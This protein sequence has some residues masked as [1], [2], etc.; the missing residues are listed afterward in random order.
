[1]KILYLSCH[2][3]L[4]FDEVKLLHELGH[5]VFSPGAYVEPANPGDASLRPGIPELVYDPDVLAAFHALGQPGIDN[6]ELLTKEFVDRF[7]LIIIMHMPKWII[8]NWE[9]MKH[10]PVIWRTIG[11]SITSVETRLAEYRDSGMKI[12]RY[13]PMES[14][15]PGYLGADALIRFYK[16]PEE[17]K[18]WSGNIRSIISFSQS[19]KKR[20][21]ACNFSYFEEITRG[22][23]RILYGP[24]NEDIFE[25]PTG[26]KLPFDQLQMQLR[27]NRV[28]FYTGTHPASYTLNFMEAWMT[29]IPIV[30][31][32]QQK[33]NANYFPSHSLYEIP[34]LI[35]NGING[36]ISEDPK[37]LRYICEELLS[38]D[39][40]ARDIG[41]AGRKSAIDIFGKDIIKQQWKEFLDGMLK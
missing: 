39:F 9:V 28:Y 13:S 30:A 38:N 5:Q 25:M 22:L 24:G 16:D 27:E 23:P 15:I 31:I 37:E 14:N 3:I 8:K 21:Q 10:K 32:G 2:S 11:Q 18:D 12:V 19:M 6:K 36:F 33:G 17:Y 40:L 4:E 20:N 26:G 41:N 34:N 29:G 1:M 35:T 7:D